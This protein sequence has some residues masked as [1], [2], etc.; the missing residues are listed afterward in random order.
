MNPTLRLPMA[1]SL[2]A[3]IRANATVLCTWM[4]YKHD[5]TGE[6][7]SH[8]KHP[9][10]SIGRS[11]MIQLTIRLK[12]PSY[13]CLLKMFEFVYIGFCSYGNSASSLELRDYE[14]LCT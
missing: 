6:A 2:T 14:L 4:A 11:V 12:F 8:D 3:G 10:A 13:S 7:T 5:W 1:V 9:V